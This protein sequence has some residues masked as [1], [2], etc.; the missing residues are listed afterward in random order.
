M[1]S[2]VIKSGHD[3]RRPHSVAFNFEDI[4]R[5]AQRQLD[6]YR[7][8]AAQI[9]AD[10]RTEAEAIRRRAEQEGRQAALA[11][12]E[13]VLDDKVRKN[14]ETLLPALRQTIETIAHSKGDWQRHWERSA[15]HLAA[16]IAGRVIRREATRT[17]DITLKL[18]QEALE[19][20]VGCPKIT[21]HLNPGDH[22]TLGGQVRKLADEFSR[23]VP[24]EIVAD[25]A[26]TPGGCRIETEY[27]AIDQQFEAQLNRI[28]EELVS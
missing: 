28:E 15:I 18:V 6:E 25:P 10:A 12:A 2:T 7:N 11:A 1:T 22:H 21:I 19:L 16:A 8:Q 14:M 24:S 3:V 9:L 27:G 13:R 5:Q 23:L 4:A 26:I 17:P 20:S